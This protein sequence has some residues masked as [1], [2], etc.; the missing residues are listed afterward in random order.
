MSQTEETQPERDEPAIIAERRAKLA[1]LR[2]G[3]ID[4]F[5]HDFPERVEIDVVRA[6]HEGL[7]AGEETHSAYRVAGRITA[8]RDMGKVAFLD[9]VDR[10]GRIQLQSRSADLGDAH[11]ALTGLDLGDIVG[12]EGTAFKSRRGELTLRVTGWTLLAKSLVPPADKWSGLEDT[13][14]RYRHR[15]RDLIAN[16]EVRERFVLRAKIIAETRRWLDDEGF[17]EVET[18][19]LQPIYGGA[20][21]RPFV[22]H[23][24]VLDRDLYLRIATE[25][26]LKRLIVGGIERVYELGKDFRNEGVSFKHNPEFT[27]LE[28]YE[29]YADYGNAAERLERLV[30][31]VAQTALGTTTV[32][33]DGTRIQLAPPWKRVTLR[34]AIREATGIDVIEHRNHE[35]LAKAMGVEPKAEHGWGKLV[36]DLLSKEVEPKLV[37]PTFITDYPVEMSPFA[38]AHRTDE[39]LVERWE[40]YAG[41]FE[42]ANAFTELNDPD[43]QRRRFEAQAEELRRGDAEAQPMDSNYIQALES[44]MPPTGGVGLG[45]D[46]L[47]M[48]LTGARSL[49][50]VV[51]F[52]A[53]RE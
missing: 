12:I 30:A 51:L 38:K 36:D 23:H 28:W 17:V 5:P 52:P 47:V 49:R 37:Q 19:V 16:P 26:Y 48:L 42:I 25:L 53:M 22:T 21:A 3:G 45:M 29:A 20:L 14:T 43:E 9:L 35:T 33:R 27:M 32:E 24:N 34:D 18:P 2:E 44:G 40:A 8:N 39:G 1:R 46:R 4:P 13:E 15:E 7:E 10:S 50:E 31:H 6:Q 41:G 11:E